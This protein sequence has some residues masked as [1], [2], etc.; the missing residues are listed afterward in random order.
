MQ[1]NDI[2]ELS[3]ERLNY[4]FEVYTRKNLLKVG[5]GEDNTLQNLT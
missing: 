5:K 3:G 1:Q 2:D 4:M